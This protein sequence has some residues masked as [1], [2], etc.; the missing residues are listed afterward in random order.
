MR[1]DGR[2]ASTHAKT[3]NTER[4]AVNA[5]PPV[6][7]FSNG[8]LLTDTA[9]S[10]QSRSQAALGVISLTLN[11]QQW[12]NI[13]GALSIAAAQAAT[14]RNFEQMFVYNG[15]CGL[16]GQRLGVTQ[17][18]VAGGDLPPPQLTRAASA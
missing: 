7:S 5:V 4:A 15:I 11:R 3:N 8:D 13:V 17:Q 6:E 18:I 12:T 10:S 14:E 1:H 9:A 16:V 2:M